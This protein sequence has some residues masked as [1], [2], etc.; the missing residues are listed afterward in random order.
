MIY[1]LQLRFKQA[2]RALLDIGWLLLLLV[3]PMILLF[4]LSLL[5]RVQLSGT[6]YIATVGLLL[7]LMLHSRR[8]DHGFLRLLN[9]SPRLVFGME[10]TVAVIPFSLL[11][12]FVLNDWFNPLLLHFGALVIA[13][14][15]AGF[16]S[17]FQSSGGAALKWMP[18]R[19]FELKCT[20]RKEYKWA[21]LLYII[22]LVTSYFTV[23]MPVV[24]L[25]F[26]LM[27][28]GAFDP[29]ENR[30]LLELTVD[31]PNW[32]RRKIVQ[33]VSVFQMAMLPFYFLFLVFHYQYWLVLAAIIFIGIGLMIFVVSYKYAHYYPGRQTANSQLPMAL[34][35]LF[36]ANPFFAPATLVYLWVYYRMANRNMALYI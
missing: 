30:N 23:S 19:F 12:A 2:Y 22:G 25:L 18:T 17:F 1:L 33:Q 8:Q 35:I 11:A 15:P 29:I 28:A 31:K 32:L 21:I 4:I 27:A 3:A 14:L 20:L 5:E 6:P 26:M 36:L 10:Y 34:F 13:L 16:S 24:V 7:I 9:Y